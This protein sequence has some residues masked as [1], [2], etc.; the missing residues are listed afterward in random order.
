M[1]KATA[2][3]CSNSLY[4]KLSLTAQRIQL[5]IFMLKYRSTVADTSLLG[6]DIK[7]KAAALISHSLVGHIVG[8]LD[9]LPDL[10]TTAC[11]T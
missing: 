7:W 5:M 3:P 2:K 9:I 11:D 8:G 4:L 6:S 10:V 1:L